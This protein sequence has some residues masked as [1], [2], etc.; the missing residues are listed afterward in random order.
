MALGSPK[1]EMISAQTTAK[2]DED[3]CLGLFGTRQC[4]VAYR[5]NETRCHCTYAIYAAS[6]SVSYQLKDKSFLRYQPKVKHFSGI[7][8]PN[9]DGS[10]LTLTSHV[11]WRFCVVT[12]AS[13]SLAEQVSSIIRRFPNLQ[14]TSRPKNL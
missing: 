10:Q 11:F 3:G 7:N 4:V 5:H 14:T 1:P 2:A 8:N 12:M 13:R 6:H 9:C